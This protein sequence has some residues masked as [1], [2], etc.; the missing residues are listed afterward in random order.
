MQVEA[1]LSRV[2]GRLI[3][4]CQAL[5][6]EPLHGS[7]IMARMALAAKVGGAAAIRAN[8]PED[9]RAIRALVDLPLIGLY[10]DGDSGVYI[11]PTVDH[12][13]QVAD[14]GADIVALD[15]TGRPRPNGDSL[16]A[17]IAAVHSR[18]KLVLA[19]VSTL[20]E[21]L[22][23]QALGADLA[24]PTL[25]GYTDYSPQLEGPDYALIQMMVRH[26]SIPVIAEGRVRTPEE[27]RLALEYGAAA[28]VVGSAITRP[29]VITEQFVKGLAKDI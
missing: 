9:V 6:D 3:V 28:V 20:D 4:S 26:L 11:T 17:Q 1:F 23:A 10:K 19:D 14:A 22:A 16:E 13:L 15:A 27:A 25:S 12:A 2:R 18:G 24:A 29:Q 7:H 21:A 5:E 8:S